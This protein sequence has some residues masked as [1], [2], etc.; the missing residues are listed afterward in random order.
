MTL[1]AVEGIEPTSLDYRSSA[2]PL[3][4][5]ARVVD[6]TGL[7]PAPHG[8]KGR[9]SV[10]R[11][12]GQ[13]GLAVAEGFE[14]SIA[15]L[16]IRCLTNLATPQKNWLRRRDSNSHT[17][18]YKTSA[19]LSHLATPPFGVTSPFSCGRGV[20]PTMPLRTPRSQAV[21]VLPG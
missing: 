10:T 3:S 11:A 12:P 4:Y 21:T 15:G 17:L 14:P 8:L 7:K 1:V 16:T 20:R 9:R 13:K 5:T 2:L 19:L 18:V 6:P